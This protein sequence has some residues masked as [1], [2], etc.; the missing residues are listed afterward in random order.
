MRLILL[1]VVKNIKSKRGR[2]LLISNW[3]SN[4]AHYH[5]WWHNPVST[6]LNFIRFH[7]LGNY[8]LS[9]EISNYP[10]YNWLYFNFLPCSTVCFKGTNQSD[11]NFIKEDVDPSTSSSNVFH[12]QASPPSAVKTEF[13]LL[14][15]YLTGAKQESIGNVVT[16]GNQNVVTSGNQN[17]VT[18]G[19]QDAGHQLFK[20]RWKEHGNRLREFV[21]TQYQDKDSSDLRLVTRKAVSVLA[22][23]LVMAAASPYFRTVLQV[24]WSKS[25]FK[26][27][28]S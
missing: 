1:L 19:N 16:S 18:S 17:V 27:L 3:C 7:Y 23:R 28:S 8:S 15:S 24:S 13:P 12:S 20:V 6:L 2:E 26:L 11:F 10:I 4:Q 22:H 5:D 14:N 9:K 25:V 21:S